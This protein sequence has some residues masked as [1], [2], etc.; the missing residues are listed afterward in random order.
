MKVR[1]VIRF[2]GQIMQALFS[3]RQGYLPKV[4]FEKLA[5]NTE[6]GFY[7]VQKPT[8]E[9]FQGFPEEFWLCVLSCIFQNYWA[10]HLTRVHL[11]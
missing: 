7:V 6:D 1:T 10:E 2:F 8:I 3:V 5:L 11:R 9:V 4:G